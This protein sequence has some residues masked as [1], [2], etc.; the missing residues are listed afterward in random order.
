MFKADP[1]AQKHSETK[2]DS[3]MASIEKKKRNFGNPQDLI[4]K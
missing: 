1:V 4:Y 3:L 2:R